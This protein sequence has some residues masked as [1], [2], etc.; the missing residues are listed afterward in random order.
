MDENAK[1]IAL[2]LTR[3]K[4]E[5]GRASISWKGGALVGAALILATGGYAFGQE[6]NVG[7]ENKPAEVTMSAEPANKADAK[8][9]GKVQV[10]VGASGEAKLFTPGAGKAESFRDCATD[11]PEMVVVPSGS[12]MMGSP[13]DEPGRTRVEGPQHRV[14]IKQPFAVGKYS[15]TF[16]EWDACV[17]DGGCGGYKPSDQGWG[18]GDRPVMNVNWHDAKAYAA[19]LSKKTGKTYRLLSEAEREYVA[20]AGTMTPFWWGISIT[21]DQANYDGHFVYKGGGEKGEYRHRTVPVNSFQANPWGLYQVHGNVWEWTEDCWNNNHNGASADG[22][23]R[24][25]GLCDRRV[26]RG[27]PWSS[28][29]HFLRSAFRFG[30]TTDLRYDYFGFRLARTLVR[31]E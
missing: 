23:A 6:R 16:A 19:W 17:A 8:T 18:R 24:T 11:C 22:S 1:A 12:F 9:S 2:E 7:Q 28:N 14:T 5:H 4:T 3:R 30:G 10:N 25:T 20:R 26:L 21:P 29:P 13:E 15:V 27:A 31:Q